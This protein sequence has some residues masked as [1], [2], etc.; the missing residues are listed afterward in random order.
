MHKM[1]SRQYQTRKMYLLLIGKVSLR[2]SFHVKKHEG[3]KI[4]FVN[5][6]YTEGVNKIPTQDEYKNTLEGDM[7][8]N[9]KIIN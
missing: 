9:R 8:L 3:Y 4:L 7:D 2:S 1:F 6:E 5:S